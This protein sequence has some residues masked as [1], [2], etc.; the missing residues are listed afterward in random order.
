MY[1]NTNPMHNYGGFEIEADKIILRSTSDKTVELPYTGNLPVSLKADTATARIGVCVAITRTPAAVLVLTD[2]KG[3]EHR[4]TLHATDAELEDILQR[5]FFTANGGTR[6]DGGLTAYWT[7]FAQ[8][9]FIAWQ[10]LRRH[11]CSASDLSGQDTER[12]A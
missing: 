10:A 8:A 9:H 1:I 5:F 7:G 12:S 3:K 4:Y 6:F 11:S 2:H